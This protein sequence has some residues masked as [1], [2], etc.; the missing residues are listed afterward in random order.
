[1][2][3]QTTV[4]NDSAEILYTDAHKWLG[5]ITNIVEFRK[6]LDNFHKNLVHFMILNVTDTDFVTKTDCIL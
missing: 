4:A 5:G 1:M 6:F 3:A 2:R